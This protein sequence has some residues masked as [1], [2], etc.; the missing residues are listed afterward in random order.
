ML[1]NKKIV[2]GVTG[3]IAVFKAA[4][5]ASKLTQLHADLD[6]I[7]TQNACKLISPAL[8]E[9]LT[10]RKCHTDTFENCHDLA[11]SHVTLGSQADLVVIAPCTANMMAKIAHGIADDKLSTTMLAAHCPIIIAPAMNCFMYENPA[12]QENIAILRRR[13]ITVL[14]PGEGPLACGYSARGRMPEP[15]DLTD[16]IV[17]AMADDKILKNKKVLIT[18]GPTREPIDAVRFISNPSTGKMGYACAKAALMAGAEVTLVTGPTNLKPVHGAQMIPVQTAEQMYAAVMDAAKT[19]DIVIMSAAVAD[20]TPESSVTSK[21]HKTD[22]PLNIPLKHTQDILKTLGENRQPG[23]ILC[24]FCMETENLLERAQL[25]LK[26]KAVDM[27]VAN[28]LN[29]R[30]CGFAGDTNGV[31]LVTRES[32]RSLEVADKLD[33]AREIIRSLAQI[34]HHEAG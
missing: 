28:D 1:K 15:E 27:I 7:L 8:F 12:T 20:F 11:S 30:G 26:N 10:H 32:V 29:A 21:M 24:G 31:M 3:S 13:G 5:L 17:Q 23:Q 18:A 6:V 14:E 34:R 9:G 22:A 4:A 25:K 19:A 33:I 2:L 16:I